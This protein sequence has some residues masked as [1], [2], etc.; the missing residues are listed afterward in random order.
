MRRKQENRAECNLR[1]SW[2]VGKLSNQDVEL[3]LAFNI[4]RHTVKLTPN[5]ISVIMLL[6]HIKS[7]VL[8]LI[9]KQQNNGKAG[10]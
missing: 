7:V 1:S 8:I 3:V 10:N 2:V 4:Y 9:N 6:T 5:E